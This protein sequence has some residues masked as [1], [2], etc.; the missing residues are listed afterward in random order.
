MPNKDNVIVID[1][2]Y[3]EEKYA[4]LVNSLHTHKFKYFWGDQHGSHYWNSQ[5]E[6]EGIVKDACVDLW[7]EFRKKFINH[8]NL[9]GTYINGQTFGLEPGPHYDYYSP[10]GITVINYITDTW[11]ITWGG[12]TLIYD[13]YAYDDAT[14]KDVNSLLF[15]PLTIDAAILPAYN[16]IIAFPS[17]QL[18]MVKPISRF[19]QGIRFTLMYKLQGVTM[20]QLMDGYMAV[21]PNKVHIGN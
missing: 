3:D 12:E 16:R 17:N 7:N 14:L 10:D 19:F 5:I 6:E 1:D 9:S 2:F 21:D 11:N 13:R 4:T 15:S 18:H 20:E 8:G